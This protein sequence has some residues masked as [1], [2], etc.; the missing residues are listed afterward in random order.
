MKFKKIDV[1]KYK[2][3]W[4]QLKSSIIRT[5]SFF[6][7]TKVIRDVTYFAKFFPN[8]MEFS[9]REEYLRQDLNSENLKVFKMGGI[10]ELNANN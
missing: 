1:F 7:T 10:F 3:K 2:N 9:D 5:Q 8:I 6:F 4:K